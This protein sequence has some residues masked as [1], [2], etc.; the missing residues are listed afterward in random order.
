MEPGHSIESSKQYKGVQCFICKK[1][2]Y[3]K[4]QFWYR[5]KEANVVKEGKGKEQEEEVAF[6][7]IS[8]E[9]KKKGGIWL[10]HSGSSNQMTSDKNLLHHIEATPS[11]SISVRDGKALKVEG[12][13]KITL[14]SSKG[15]IITLNDVQFVPNI[16]H[17]FLSVGQMIDS[18]FDVEF[19][20]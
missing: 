14:C 16:A 19:D 8:E 13:G 9:P 15:K 7:A 1:Y 3:V 2:G 4:A 5:N 20:E 12:I 6:M 18:K 11:H 10:I 17:S